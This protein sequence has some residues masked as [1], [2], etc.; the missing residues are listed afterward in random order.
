MFLSLSH[1]Y[2]NKKQQYE[3]LNWQKQHWVEQ[4]LQRSKS[5]QPIKTLHRVS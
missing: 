5:A 3:A 2:V 4:H 1:R